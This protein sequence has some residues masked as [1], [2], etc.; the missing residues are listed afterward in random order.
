M[1]A[2][3]ESGT[4]SSGGSEAPPVLVVDD[5]AANLVAIQAILSDLNCQM[6]AARSGSEALQR[7]QE[8]AYA[9]VLMDIRM[10]ELDGFATASFM[11]QRVESSETPIIFLTAEDIERTRLNQAYGLGAIDF[12]VKPFEAH[13]LRSKVALF[14][15][16]F[17]LRGHARTAEGSNGEHREGLRT[18][19][20]WLAMV[21]HD[22]RQPLAAT[23]LSVAALLRHTSTPEV[24]ELQRMR[25]HYAVIQRAIIHMERMVGDLLDV[26]RLESGN[27]AVQLA[28]CSMVDI[29]QQG[30]ELLSPI[31]AERDIRL[32]VARVL[33]PCMV[34]CERDRILQ[35]LSN[36]V[37]NAIK[38]SSPGGSIVV[39][40]D[41]GQEEVVVAVRDAGPGIPEEHLSHVFDKY[42]Q[43]QRSGGGLGLGLP[44]V[45]SI[46]S[47]HGGRVW[48][49]S[50]VGRGSTFY[51]S[52]PLIGDA[53][54]FD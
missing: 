42:W 40:C 25:R 28:P 20:D 26:S 50:D 13:V 46:I 12:L 14:V 5:H 29:L 35:V 31:A 30:A 8:R 33:S 18:R 43:G 15:E 48:L 2:S 39:G 47:A 3:T 49:E 37:G 6:V 4:P 51:F 10:P 41:I 27:F 23:S 34:H 52:L 32:E 16:L 53:Q 7:I 21:A 9:A 54:A 38:F 19:E 44:I 1:S 24:D 11:R 17:R 36:L 45:R 22:L